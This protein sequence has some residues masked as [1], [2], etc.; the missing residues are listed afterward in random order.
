MYEIADM[1]IV[2]GT[3]VMCPLHHW[4][5][6]L[7]TGQCDRGNFVLDMYKVKEED[8]KVFV[9]TKPTN[10]SKLIKRRRTRREPRESGPPTIK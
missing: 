2:W 8:G 3:A 6:N 10:E 5:F 9:G 4:S 1:G 7:E